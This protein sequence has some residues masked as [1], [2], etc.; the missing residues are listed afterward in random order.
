MN[1]ALTLKMM[2]IT[3]NVRNRRLELNYTQ[4]YVAKKLSISQNA[5]SKIERGGSKM[6]VERLFQI[7]VILETDIRE[8][9]SITDK[10][11]I[12]YLRQL[13]IRAKALNLV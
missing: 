1:K 11:P 10:L 7:A 13:S 2:I 8:L 9:I 4:E 5:Y 12:D 3:D 6:T